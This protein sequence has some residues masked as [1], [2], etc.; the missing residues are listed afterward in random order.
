MAAG[1]GFEPSHTESESAVL[2]LHNPAKRKSYYN[3]NFEFVNTYFTIFSKKFNAR[4]STGIFVFLVRKEHL[5]ALKLHS[6][7]FCKLLHQIVLC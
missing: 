1:E 6:G 4:V 3:S 2:P 7:D 5:I